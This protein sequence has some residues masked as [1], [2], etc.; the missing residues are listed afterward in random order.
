MAVPG[1]WRTYF[2]H[3]VGATKEF[4]TLDWWLWRRVFR[5]LRK[6]HRGI[7]THALR[8]RYRR[9]TPTG[10]RVWGEGART[11]ATFVTVGPRRTL[12]E[13]P[14]SRA[15]GTQAFRGSVWTRGRSGLP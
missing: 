15:H 2:R 11:M 9:L 6:K 4:A 3:A 8:R 7:G 1:G 5:W 12:T 14:T 10:A 13:E